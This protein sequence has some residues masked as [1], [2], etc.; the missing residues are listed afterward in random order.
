VVASATAVTIPA[1]GMA[2]YVVASTAIWQTPLYA[3]A[4]ETAT[5]AVTRGS[6]GGGLLSYVWQFYLP[7]LPFMHDQWPGTYPLYDVWF[8]GFI[9]RFGW[10]DY[11]FPSWVYPLAAVIAGGI[12]VLAASTLWKLRA[13]TSAR[14]YEAVTYLTLVV[15]VL[16]L[17]AVAGHRYRLDTGFTFEQARYLLPLL[18]LY[19][20]VVA[21]AAAAG[22]RRFGPATGAALVLAAMTHGIFAQLVTLA[23]YYG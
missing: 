18:P 20:T 2:I 12:L 16:G 21:L 15:G 8:R 14:W 22:A 7:R 9:G 1:V 6:T 13:R 10:L 4:G 17:I 23:R 3:G 11:G 5:G 19:G